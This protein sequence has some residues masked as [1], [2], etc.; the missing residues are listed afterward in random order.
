MS[1]PPGPANPPVAELLSLAGQTAL[2]TGAGK[3]IGEAIARRLAEAGARVAITDIDVTAGRAVADGVTRAGGTARFYPLDVADPAQI[4]ATIRAVLG[5]FGSLDVLVNNAGIFP[6]S[7]AMETPPQWWDRVFATNLRG[8][9]FLT[10]AAVG[11]MRTAGH[12]S[13]V[14]VASIDAVRPA[15]QLAHYDA[16]KAGLAMLTRSLALEFAAYGV[17]VNAVAPGAVDT[18]GARVALGGSGPVPPELLE[19]FLGRIPVHRMGTPDE[20]ARVVLFLASSMSSYIT[21]A[22]IVADGGYLLA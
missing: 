20:I 4:P 19:R 11:W 13:V 3:G 5:E 6:F 21:G 15:G 18:P 12:G 1:D 22:M 17:R 9:F 16:S 2:V 10:Q 7:P 8:A 14:N